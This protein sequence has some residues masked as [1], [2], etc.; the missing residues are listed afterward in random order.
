MG[1]KQSTDKYIFKILHYFKL[2]KLALVFNELK[3]IPRSDV[4]LVC[5][6]GDRSFNYYNKKYA[7]LLD[8]VNEKLVEAGIKTV[9][10]SLPIT[11]IKSNTA[12]GNVFSVNGLIARARIRDS[13]GRL[14][15]RRN[16]SKN[17]NLLRAW[18]KIL[19][20][21]Q[22]KLIIGIQP[23]CELCIAAKHKHIC[24]NDLQHG[25]LSDEGYYGLNYREQYS[26]SGWPDFILCWNESSADWIHKN[27]NDLI[28]TKVIGH[29]WI[30]RFMHPSSSDMLVQK[31]LPLLNGKHESN[32]LTI[33]ITLQRAEL[34]SP[35]NHE[36]GIPL[37]LI[38]LIKDSKLGYQWWIRIHPVMLHGE[39]RLKTLSSLEKEFKN[40]SDVHWN[41]CTELPLALVLQKVDLHITSSSAV[42]IEASWF[43][44]KTALLNQNTDL[45]LTWL[46]K[47]INNGSAEIVLPEFES[48]DRWIKSNSKK[49]SI[50]VSQKYEGND[51]IDN[52]ISSVVKDL[53]ESV[54]IGASLSTKRYTD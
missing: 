39:G 41:H 49:A 4:L 8:S 10:I 26:Q 13:I 25:I 43:G 16:H 34:S 12:Y 36:L 45:L 44:I 52:F 42:T 35:V 23:P 5:T 53:S 37:E 11:E 21:I 7:P 6:D 40:C 27:L 46:R 38:R 14:A 29:P 48:I 32:R 22:P 54:S 17:S 50:S 30:S 18:S 28:G 24:V 1:S 31:Y 19:E 15:N 47:E 20:K 9:T 51:F 33:L 3:K 2:I